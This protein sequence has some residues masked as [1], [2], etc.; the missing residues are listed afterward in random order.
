MRYGILGTLE[1]SDDGRAIDVSGAKQRALVAV[2]LINAN[3]V[4]ASDELID[5]LWEDHAP[6]TARKALQVLVSQLRKLLG[7]ERVVTKGPGYLLRVDAD[8]LDL[9]RFQRLVDE[10]KPREALSVWRGAPLADFTYQRFAQSEIGRLEE[11]RL[12]TL[13]DRIDAD[14]L[15]GRHAEL[16]GELESLIALHPLRERLRGQLML[17][18]YRSARQAEAL[19]AYQAARWVLVEE[20]GIDP[21]RALRELHQAIL[22]QDPSLDLQADVQPDHE[23]P[24]LA[25]REP[26]PAAEPAQREARKTVTAVH[27]GIALSPAA[28]ETLDLEARRRVTGRAFAGVETAVDRHGGIVE[29][30]TGEA[31]TAVF[32]L[33][34]VHED[35]AL[36]GMR[37]AAEVRASLSELADELSA[38]PLE[39]EFRVGLSTGEVVTG[40]DAASRVR[41]TGE[42]LRRAA[43]LAQAARPGEILFDEGA[44]RLVREAVTSERTDDLWRLVGLEAA[45][46]RSVRTLASTLVG[47]ARE[48]RRLHDAFEQAEGDRTCQLFTVLGPAGVGKSRLVDEFLSDIATRALVAR[49]RCLPYGEGITHWP[50]LEVIKDAVGLEDG[51]SAEE[52]LAKLET[53]L[54]GERDAE[55][56]ALRIA[57]M[58]GLVGAGQG[59]QDGFA[60]VQTLFE[61][62][63]RI[64]PL[65]VVFDDIHWGEATFLDLVEHLADWT[66]DVPVVLACLARPELLD[67]RPEWAGGKLN[68]TSLLLE[69]LSE[70]ESN[71]LIEN[72]DGAALA[73]RTK[74][75]I[76]AAAEGNPLFVEEML[77][78]VL[79]DGPVESEVEVPPTIQALLAARLDRLGDAERSVIECAA[80]VGKVFYEG[81]VAE[82][83]TAANAGGVAEALGALVRKE[84]I[85]PDR[86][87]LGGRSFRFRH[88]LI[89]DAAYDSIPKEARADMHERF[90]GWLERAAGD[91]AIEYEEVVGYHLEQ[92]Y[93][94]TVQLGPVD[95]RSRSLARRAADRLGEAGR[96]AFVRSDA[97]AGINLISRA[98]ALLP[99]EDP[100]RVDLV[101]NVRVVQGTNVDWSW[102]DTAL[103]EAVETAAT[104]GDRRLAAQALVQRGLLRLFTEPN[105]TAEELIDAAERSIA[106][107]DELGDELGLARAW[108]LSAQAHYLARRA[109]L[110][111]DAS[112]RALVHVRRAQDRYERTE[113]VEWLTIALLLG[114]A[115]APAAADR[116]RRL[117]AETTDDLLLT[118]EILAALATLEAMLGRLGEASELIARARAIMDDL[119]RPIWIVSFWLSFVSSWR[120]DPVAAERDVRPAY[121]AL[122]AIGEK[123]HFSSMCHA[124]ANAVYLQGRY[125]EA[126]LLTR[127]CEE[128]S[129]PNDVQS[130]VLWRSIRAK[131]LARRGELEAA[132]LLALESIAFAERSDFLTAHADALIDLAEV[133]E[134]SE[135]PSDAVH[136]IEKAI[137]V[138]ELKGN[139][140]AASHARSRLLER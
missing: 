73:E 112:E 114:P 107:F 133:L 46:A 108:R 16:V 22:N 36:R 116:C 122:K 88:L 66:R 18:L 45:T 121:D 51:D 125:E 11:L 52:V 56:V 123:S 14:L 4:V 39:L 79:E 75:R 103:T 126:E 132:E 87:S 42:P 117:L 47:R 113:I 136:S 104:T 99:P 106:V 90:A 44:W 86:P 12:A 130:Q 118:A 50:V 9:D 5:A 23:Q 72:L 58:V 28:G 74:Q 100:L 20:L 49:G 71:E 41:A 115:P 60:A 63:G 7:R 80:V 140:F 30:V 33:P 6:E 24:A 119:G 61:C 127:E 53:A 48:R 29:T 40:L 70:S 67:V 81:A 62:L 89:R 101:P 31:V 55:L 109:G 97:P 69:P 105:V 98:V 32:G 35:D 95:D 92:A 59:V 2:L 3:R 93:R 68:A 38:R 138:Y 111:A 21:G 15:D 85:R 96:R 128:A 57:E 129:R 84:L 19:E 25:P 26:A 110:C 124:L 1:V 27:V 76:V 78:L 34:S 13:E 77:A 83:V 17:A 37:A 137:R 102:A 139:A 43:Q 134:L 64:R 135:R 91:R 120:E 10:G 82:L 54:A 131:A 65:V 94:Y 8:E